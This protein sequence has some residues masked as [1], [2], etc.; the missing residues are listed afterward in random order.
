MSER[1]TFIRRVLENPADDT[2]RLVFADWL[3]EQDDKFSRDRALW[4]RGPHWSERRTDINLWAASVLMG[5][6]DLPPFFASSGCT[7]RRG[8]I[9]EVRVPLDTFMKHAKAL[10]SFQPIT[11]VLLSDVDAR[12]TGLMPRSFDFVCRILSRDYYRP[13]FCRHWLPLS[14]SKHLDNYRKSYSRIGESF[15][16]FRNAKAAQDALNRCCVAYGRFLAGLPKLEVKGV[17]T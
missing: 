2:A 6:A 4:F 1:E 16:S 8:F 15:H 10:F 3:E 14:F 17:A 5:Y 13:Q 9:E 12:H 7:I 11:S